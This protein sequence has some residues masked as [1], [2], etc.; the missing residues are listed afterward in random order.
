VDRARDEAA[1]TSFGKVDL[2]ANG[3]EVE[4][5]LPGGD[6]LRWIGTSMASPQVVNLAAKLFAAYP[7]LGA[8][9]VKKLIVDG[10]DKKDISGGR[11]I[12]LLN[13]TRSFELARASGR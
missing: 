10:A 8:A 6:K 12:R 4:S 13:E 5:L 1:F 7:Q 2:Y 3:Y 11:S 9:E